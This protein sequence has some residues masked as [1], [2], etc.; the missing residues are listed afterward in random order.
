[1]PPCRPK[2]SSSAT[3]VWP[4]GRP[5]LKPQYTYCMVA[6][7]YICSIKSL[8]QCN[9]SI[10]PSITP[11]RS[12]GPVNPPNDSR[13]VLFDSK[14]TP[15]GNGDVLWTSLGVELD[16]HAVRREKNC[17]CLSNRWLH[18]SVLIYMQS[19]N[20]IEYRATAIHIQGILA[21]GMA[22]S[23]IHYPTPPRGSI[24]RPFIIYTMKEGIGDI[25]QPNLVPVISKPCCSYRSN[26]SYTFLATG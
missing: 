8:Y 5:A 6:S 9:F 1:M 10:I 19:I 20:T 13:N 21:Q 26:R 23:C 4:I 18:D 2:Q 24:F 25:A 14:R 15:G 7:T 11:S 16:E 12:S 17:A 22:G 3:H